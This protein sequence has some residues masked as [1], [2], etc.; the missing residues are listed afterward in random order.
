MATFV[1]SYVFYIVP[2]YRGG[3]KMTR[4][5]LRTGLHP[6]MLV[7]G[8]GLLRTFAIH[9][10]KRSQIPTHLRSLHISCYDLMFQLIGRFFMAMDMD[11]SSFSVF[12]TV[13]VG[14]QEY[15]LRANAVNL[16]VSCGLLLSVQCI[17]IQADKEKNIRGCLRYSSRNFSATKFPRATPPDS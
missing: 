11:D 4:F 1:G 3:S 15:L 2:S 13:V 16:E 9:K 6:C 10:H 5:I 8:D 14:V 12:C 17:K 7:F